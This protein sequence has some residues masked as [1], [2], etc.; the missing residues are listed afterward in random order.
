[1]AVRAQGQGHGVAQPAAQIGQAVAQIAFGAGADHHSCAAARHGFDL[2]G[3]AVR[4]MHQLPARIQ[5]H[6]LRQPLHGAMAGVGQA[7][8]HL[9][10]LLGNVDVN[11]QVLRAYLLQQLGDGS[12][13]GGAQGVDCHTRVQQAAA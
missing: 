2:G 13:G 6:G 3:F 10:H 1:M 4:G 8:A 9:L 12:G 7:V 11:G 5:R